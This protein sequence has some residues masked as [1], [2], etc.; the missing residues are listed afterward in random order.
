MG[1]SSTKCGDARQGRRGRCLSAGP[2]PFASRGGREAIRRARRFRDRPGGE[3]G[4]RR[5]PH[6]RAGFTDCLLRRGASACTRSTSG[7]ALA[8][9]PAAARPARRFPRK[10]VNFRHAPGICFAGKVTLAVRRRFLHL[11]SGT[12]SRV[13]PALPRPRAE[14]LPLRKAAVRGGKARRQGGRR[15]GRRAA[16]GGGGRNRGVRP[17]ETG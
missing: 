14:A 15:P 16:P 1:S 3:R 7:S 2:R 11:P 10:K 6:R 17:A 13:L 9:R 12:S 8:R 4:A 5:G